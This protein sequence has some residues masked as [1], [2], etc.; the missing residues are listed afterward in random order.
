MNRRLSAVV[1]AIVVGVAGFVAVSR[2]NG[3]APEGTPVL[4]PGAVTV[5]L[6][7]EHS[8]FTPAIVRVREGTAVTFQVV[9]GDP[10]GHELII[11][12]SDVHARHESGHEASHPPVPGEVSVP[13]LGTADTTFAFDAGGPSTVVFAC[14]L[15]GH[16]AYGMRGEIRVVA[17]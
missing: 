11:G 15:P 4:G 9:N 12:G 6:R 7:I 2:A 8:H 3:S 13:P 17:A 16:F 10:I 1:V 14:H 5:Q